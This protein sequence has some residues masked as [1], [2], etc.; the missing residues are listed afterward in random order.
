MGTGLLYA[1]TVSTD[2]WVGAA[3]TLVGAVL[4]GS[5][6]YTV[7]RQQ[8]KEARAQRAEE[9]QRDKARR[10]LDRRFDAY[11]TFISQARAYRNAI[12]PY[13]LKTGPVMTV[14]EIDI[15][16]RS[17]DAAGSLIF[18]VLESPRMQAACAAMMRTIGDTAGTIHAHVPDLDNVPW[19]EISEA[20]AR[21]LRDFQT[22]ARA[23]L[24]VS[25]TPGP[26]TPQSGG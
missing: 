18:L 15:L 10:S 20:M 25:S 2:L 13:R 7:S 26:V 16:A 3:T 19:E 21:A 5:I 23:E 8:I 4:G 9:E 17:A 24:G 1:P 22:A 14:A 12:R 11:A 6:S